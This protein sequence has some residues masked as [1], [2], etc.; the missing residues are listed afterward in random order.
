MP[1]SANACRR[2]HLKQVAFEPTGQPA[3]IHQIPGAASVIDA[4]EHGDRPKPEMAR[5]FDEVTYS[6]V[7]GAKVPSSSE[8]QGR[9]V[10]CS[11]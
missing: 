9:P 2:P 11:I 10:R 7:P 5:P 8:C 6:L 1:G 4:E 3:T